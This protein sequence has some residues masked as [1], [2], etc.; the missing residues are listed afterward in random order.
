MYLLILYRMLT[1]AN[2]LKTPL[3]SYIFNCCTYFFI[4]HRTQATAI[5][6]PTRTSPPTETPAT[7]RISSCCDGSNVVVV[8]RLLGEE[9]PGTEDNLK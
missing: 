6:I 8:V 7:T 2:I 9:A 3:Y 1:T 5:I 4:L